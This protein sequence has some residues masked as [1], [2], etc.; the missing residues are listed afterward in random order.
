MSRNIKNRDEL[1]RLR[2]L[3]RNL[4]KQNKQLRKQLARSTKAVDKL[5]PLVDKEPEVEMPEVEPLDA[6]KC[7]KCNAKVT[8]ID[9]GNRKVLICK[10]CNYRKSMKSNGN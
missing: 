8:P 6:A 2:G 9:M 10:K 4:E 1:E 3:N 5:I 7:D